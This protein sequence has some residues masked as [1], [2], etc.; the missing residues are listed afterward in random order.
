[1]RQIID[2]Q[3]QLLKLKVDQINTEVFKRDYIKTI[4]EELLR[5]LNDAYSKDKEWIDNDGLS[6]DSRSETSSVADEREIQHKL[7]QI[8]HILTEKN[9]GEE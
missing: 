8:L 6:V 2:R 1:M 7:K 9:Q 4:T 5:Q 3:R